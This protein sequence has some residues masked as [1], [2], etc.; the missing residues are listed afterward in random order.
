MNIAAD[1]IDSKKLKNFKGRAVLSLGDDGWIRYNADGHADL[2]DEDDMMPTMGNHHCIVRLEYRKSQIIGISLESVVTKN[3]TYY[4][5][6]I[7]INGVYDDI[8]INIIS[9]EAAQK[10]ADKILNW[11]K[12]I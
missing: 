7:S 4:Q 1:I 2:Y 9:Y 6:Q 3:G 11:I 5:I 10:A 12:N 8:I